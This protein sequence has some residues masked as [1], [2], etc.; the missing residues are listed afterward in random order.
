MNTTC[1][2]A[3]YAMTDVFNQFFEKL[4]PVLLPQMLSQFKWC[5]RQDNDQLSRSAVAC[6]ENLIVT[7]RPLMS[8]AV[9]GSVVEFLG[10]AVLVTV[11]TNESKKSGVQVHLE[12]LSAVR[13]IVTE[14]NFLSSKAN[15]DESAT[16]HYDKLMVLVDSLLVSFASGR[17]SID[18]AFDALPLLI[19]QETQSYKSALDILLALY[20]DKQN[21]DNQGRTETRILGLLGDGLAYFL[22]TSL[23][24]QRDAWSDL[25]AE[26][27][28]EI[29]NFPDSKFRVTVAV[30][31]E[32]ICDVLAVPT[33]SKEFRLVLCKVLKRVGTMYGIVDKKEAAEQ[34]I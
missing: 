13:R 22:V 16:D 6:I 17:E 28:E 25:L 29:L 4:A 11:T 3:L 26:V 12:I 24:S 27:F 19:K 8:D 5:L 1:N 15:L 14:Q 23:K 10:D 7:N 20:H 34:A 31:Y 18:K 2:H 9:E 33:V 21:H 32:G 30:L